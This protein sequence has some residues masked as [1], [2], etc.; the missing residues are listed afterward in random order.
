MKAVAIWGLCL[1][2]ALMTIEARAEGL[3]IEPYATY[4]Q[5]KASFKSS[6]GIIN[7]DGD[8]KGMGLGARVGGHFGDIVF[9]A[10]DAQ[11]ST[12]DFSSSNYS[13]KTKSLLA[14]VTLGAQTPVLGIR[15][16]GSYLPLGTLDQDRSQGLQLK[17]SEPEMMKLGVGLRV[18]M[19]SVNLEHLSGKYKKSEVQNDASS[20]AAF[21]D[22][23]ANRDSW[24]LGVS[25]PFSL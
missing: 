10:L 1:V 7:F 22:A 5:G 16:W 23:D 6:S 18:A 11:Y 12:P 24:L 25:F 13:T 9:L 8:M 20:F 14:G 2:A 19:F 3:F 15:V 21:T 17:F 4:E